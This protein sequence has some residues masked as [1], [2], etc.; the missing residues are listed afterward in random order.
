MLE[1]TDNGS[2]MAGLN[3]Y[4]LTF[5]GTTPGDKF[6]AFDGAFTGVLSQMWYYYK[7]WYSTVWVG[8]FVLPLE[9]SSA[10]LDSHLLLDPHDPSH[11]LVASGANEDLDST[12]WTPG[13][14]PP[15]DANLYQ[16]GLGTYI[17][18]TATSNMAF[19]VPVAFQK[20]IQP[21]AQIVIPDGETVHLT[22]TAVGFNA[23]G[24]LLDLDIPEPATLGL[25]AFG[26]A[27]ALIRRRRR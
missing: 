10:A 6:S 7:Q 21:F 27:G 5:K 20:T 11:V 1:I 17:S 14:T 18:T 15:P 25:L 16:R 22:G 12:G 24:L 26:A 3:S 2:P 4:T 19:A 9:A 23:Q 8:D 13:V